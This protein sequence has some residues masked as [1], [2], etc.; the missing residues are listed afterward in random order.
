M[1]PCKRL[2][3]VIND[4]FLRV[5]DLHHLINQQV[6]L[7]DLYCLYSYFF[8]YIFIDFIIHDSN[9]SNNY[10]YYTKII[11]TFIIITIILCLMFNTF[12]V[13]G[14]DGDVTS[15][16]VQS[17]PLLYCFQCFARKLNDAV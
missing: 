9:N 4:N 6:F 15:R 11:T 8:I 10:H 14:V 12:Q 2:D 5:A 3:D 17:V 16:L 13:V 1:Q 7:A